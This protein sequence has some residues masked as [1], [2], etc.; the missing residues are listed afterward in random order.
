MIVHNT[1][2]EER[3]CKVGEEVLNLITGEKY[4]FTSDLY[5]DLHLPIRLIEKD[6]SQ[7]CRKLLLI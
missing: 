1:T 3:K 2:F 5:D 6:D 4:K 7:D